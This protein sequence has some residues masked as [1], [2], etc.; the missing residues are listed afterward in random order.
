MRRFNYTNRQR[1]E[2]RHI[3]LAVCQLPDGHVAV[4]AD[5]DVAWLNSEGVEGAEV[6]VEAYHRNV[7]ER[8]YLGT[9]GQPRPLTRHRLERFRSDQHIVFRVKIVE[10][11]S[12]RLVAFAKDIRAGEDAEARRRSLLAVT[13][14]PLDGLV[15]KVDF[16]EGEAP[17]LTLNERLDGVTAG[18]VKGFAH[19]PL[20][21]ALVFP[22]VIREVLFRFLVVDEL[23]DEDSYEDGPEAKWLRFA[24]AANPDPLPAVEEKEARL[25]WIG[26]TVGQV[27]EQ[28]RVIERFASALSEET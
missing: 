20:F 28:L 15:Y 26:R 12:G 3:R 16:P 17:L 27:G 25:D 2:R 21:V 14:A 24:K 10:P 19:N 4:D 23:S 1:I 9:V 6:Y 11:S 13:V 7:F 18:G 5:V 8:L 22:S